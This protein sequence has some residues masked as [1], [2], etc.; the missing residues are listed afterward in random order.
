MLSWCLSCMLESLQDSTTRNSMHSSYSR[1]DTDV[2][3]IGARFAGLACA[4]VLAKR[5]L[6]VT[7]LERKRDVGE[8]LHTT[9]I[10][11]KEAAEGEDILQGMP[12]P[13]ARRIDGVRLYAPN[14]RH[15]DLQAPGYYFLA[16]DTPNVMRWLAH[17]A[18]EEGVR[19]VTGTGFS[20]VSAARDGWLLHG[21]GRVGHARYLVGADGPASRV[22]RV[23]GLGQNREFLEGIEYEYSLP[24][25]MADAERMHCFID[26]KLA[27]GYL[28]WMVMGVQHLQAGLA[29]R[30]RSTRPAE[31]G[32]LKQA[33]ESFLHK[34]APIADLRKETPA[35]VRAGLI[36]CGGRVAPIACE[37]ALLL[38]DAAGMVSPVTAG[39]IH[40]AL[41]HGHLAGAAI[42][43]YLQGAGAKPE[44]SLARQLPTLRLK[45]LL[46]WCFDHGQRDWV[47]NLLLDTVPMR[48]AA[49]LVYFHRQ[50]RKNKS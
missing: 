23:L 9:G 34:I 31:A 25:A 35:E 33:M 42:A 1:I 46:R 49:E 4:R 41:R 10:L 13:L 28:C 19:I 26:R 18:R 12:A 37:R 30:A 32:S 38:G 16:T 24:T 36:P 43:D 50:G 21:T 3:I 14:L 44:D 39:G 22:A 40:L 48:R 5:G 8:K 6:H 11:V 7:V 20:E 29:R 15:I 27:P 45:R 17:R 47:F 2:V